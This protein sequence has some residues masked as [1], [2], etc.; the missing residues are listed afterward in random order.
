M[1]IKHL[2]LVMAAA[3]MLTACGNKTKAQVPEGDSVPITTNGNTTNMQADGVT[4]APEEDWT[5]EAVEAR[6]KKMYDEVNKMFDPSFD[7]M[8]NL[9]GDFLTKDF[10]ETLN[11]LYE[12]DRNTD[13]DETF[14]GDTS[15][16]TWGTLPPLT[17]SNIKATLLTG[18]MAEA[19]Y[20]LHDSDVTQIDLKASLY[21][22]DGAWRVNSWLKCPMEYD[23]LLEAMKAYVKK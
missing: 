5:E 12:K 16:W 8:L 22:E 2:L 23:D 20:T 10:C 14:F 3:T 7:G 21:Y 9:E 4:A 1:T 11:A 15:I 18:D 19:T 13:E 17:V 6:I